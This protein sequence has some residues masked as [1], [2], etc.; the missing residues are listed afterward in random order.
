MCYNRDNTLYCVYVLS[1]SDRMVLQSKNHHFLAFI[2]Y[3]VVTQNDQNIAFEIDAAMEHIANAY[4]TCW[5]E[6]GPY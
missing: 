5:S 6:T 1:C 2:Q 4:N 3:L